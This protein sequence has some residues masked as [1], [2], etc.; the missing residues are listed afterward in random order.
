MICAKGSTSM[1][2]VTT[3]NHRCA[4]LGKP[5]AHSLSPVLHNAAYRALGLSD[6]HYSKHEV[7][8]D[9]LAAFLGGLDSSWAGLSLTMPLKKTIQPY[10][11]PSNLW[12]R[13]LG[14]ANTAVFDWSQAEGHDGKPH[15]RLFN[16]DVIGIQLAFEHALRQAGIVTPDQRSQRAVVIG[17]GN[18][19]SSA[20]A[21]CTMMPQIGHVTVIARHPQNNPSLRPL[22]ERFIPG[23]RVID[24]IAMD[25]EPALANELSQAD[26]VISTIP[27]LAGD[28]VAS[29]LSTV[30]S[31][32]PG[33]S[34]LDVVY[35]PRPTK[36]MSAW[37]DHGGLAIGGE[38]MLLYQALVQVLLMTGEWDG[39]PPSDSQTRLE[40]AA[41][42]DDHL[43][44]AMR[45]ALEEAL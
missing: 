11:E 27:G 39:D 19:A 13:V 38:E 29:M 10:G 12:A 22:A 30:P 17:N 3:I 18:T 16:T 32:K 15:I 14:V 20:V 34:L 36:L 21:A 35:D 7:G 1:E 33:A 42:D 8:Q 4:V 25:D 24:I 5:I 44:I 40:D 23:T 9:D 2:G 6:W 43:E 28:S 37:R 26:V 41:T 45:K 31:L